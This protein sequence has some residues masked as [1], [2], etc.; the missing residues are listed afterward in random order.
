[1]TACSS[2]CSLTALGPVKVFMSYEFQKQRRK[3]EIVSLMKFE[4]ATSA[5]RAGLP[6]CSTNLP[7]ESELILHSATPLSNSF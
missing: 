2:Q 3:E 1:M 5:C 7:V 4:E 6:A